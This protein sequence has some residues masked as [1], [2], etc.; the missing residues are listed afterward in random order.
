MHLSCL[1]SQIKQKDI[2][3]KYHSGQFGSPS[4]I[5]KIKVSAKNHTNKFV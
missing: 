2:N 4:Q 5:R 1:E 3:G